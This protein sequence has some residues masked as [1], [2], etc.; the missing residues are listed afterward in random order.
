MQYSLDRFS[1]FILKICQ[2]IPDFPVPINILL[3]GGVMG[4]SQ[5]AKKEDKKKPLKSAK[6]KKLEKQQKK[7]SK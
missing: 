1:N 6:E 4:K 2:R 7:L 5:D 3:T